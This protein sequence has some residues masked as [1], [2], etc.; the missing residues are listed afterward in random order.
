MSH[1][2]QARLR[3]Q[4]SK[5]SYVD[6]IAKTSLGTTPN[7]YNTAYTTSHT[8]HRHQALA[9][10]GAHLDHV[11]LLEAPSTVLAE[12]LKGRL[13]HPPSGTPQARS[14]LAAFFVQ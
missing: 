11:L 1:V 14:L 9:T 6:T 8:L 3:R 5:H 12:R 4:C 10:K 2:G 7:I 13:V